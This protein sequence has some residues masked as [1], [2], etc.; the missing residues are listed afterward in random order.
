MPIRPSSVRHVLSCSAWSSTICRG[1][2]CLLGPPEM[3]PGTMPV[4]HP[5][6][7]LGWGRFE[8]AELSQDVQICT[9]PG[10]LQPD[11]C[12]TN[13]CHQGQPPLPQGHTCFPFPEPRLKWAILGP[14]RFPHTTYNSLLL[15]SQPSLSSLWLSLATAAKSKASLTL[16]RN[17]LLQ[18]PLVSRHHPPPTTWVP[19]SEDPG[20]PPPTTVLPPHLCWPDFLSLEFGLPVFDK[21][22]SRLQKPTELSLLPGYMVEQTRPC[23]RLQGCISIEEGL[24]S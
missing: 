16:K 7:S 24:P 4:L 13:L 1:P 14:H 5:Y 15:L 21:H 17:P 22:P 8:R 19:Q 10:H 6:G 11:G 23:T 2:I 12:H 20:D 9:H 18:N 3:A